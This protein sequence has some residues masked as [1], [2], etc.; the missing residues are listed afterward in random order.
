MILE[1]AFVLR[2]FREDGLDRLV[3][4]N[5]GRD[6]HTPTCPEPLTAPPD[7]MRWRI[8][9]SSEDPKYGGSGTP[10]VDSDDQ[11]RRLMGEAAVVLGAVPIAGEV[12]T[13]RGPGRRIVY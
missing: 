10:V 12:I 4:V 9:L 2:F 5:F 3:V 13:Q 1:T 11:G 8:L 7:G 6:Q